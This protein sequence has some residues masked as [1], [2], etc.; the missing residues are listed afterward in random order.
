MGPPL[1]TQLFGYFSAEKAPLLVPG[2]AFFLAWVLSA[3]SLVVF[4]R[5]V[6]KT[7][8]QPAAAGPARG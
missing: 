5:A 1:M 8:L 3:A 2:A 7:P 6:R 4:R